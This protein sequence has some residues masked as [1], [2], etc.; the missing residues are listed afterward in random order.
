VDYL[1]FVNIAS[2]SGIWSI[3]GKKWQS[4]TSHW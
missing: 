4:A 2:E 1:K 3:L